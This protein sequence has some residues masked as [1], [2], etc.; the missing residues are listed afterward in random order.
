M[1]AAN[2]RWRQSV[3]RGGTTYER[4]VKGPL[5]GETLKL[6]LDGPQEPHAVRG[7][8]SPGR[9]HSMCRTLRWERAWPVLAM[10]RSFR[11]QRAGGSWALVLRALGP[12]A[13][14]WILFPVFRET[15]A[16]SPSGDGII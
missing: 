16:G 5:W 10:E 14:I 8:A 11:E 15:T 4:V 6:R 9:G 1:K 13:S 12:P 7:G 3:S 2:E